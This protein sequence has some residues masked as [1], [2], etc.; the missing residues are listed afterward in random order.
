MKKLIL[1]SVV[2]LFIAAGVQAGTT[3]KTNKTTKKECSPAECKKE[4]KDSEK[5]HECKPGE[6]KCKDSKSCDKSGVKE[7]APKTGN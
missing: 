5:K 2:V 4:C 3:E 6:S 1:S 7:I